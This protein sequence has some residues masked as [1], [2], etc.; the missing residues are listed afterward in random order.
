VAGVEGVQVVAP[1]GFGAV[2]V[3]YTDG[4]QATEFL[5]SIDP[6][7]LN[8][9]LEPEMAQ[10]ALTDLTDGGILVD[11]QRAEDHDLGIGSEVL[12]T[13][14]SGDALVFEV[15][16]ISNE[17]NL[18]GTF[19]VT[20]TEA[21]AIVPE[22]VDAQLYGLVTDGADL[23]TVLAD[24]EKAVADTPGL[25]V[26]DREGFVGSITSQITSF[27]NFVYGMLLLSIIIALIGI[28]NTLSLS[29]NERTRELGLLR[30]VGMDR[31]QLR[32]TIR[33]EA[34]LISV[35]GAAVG[36]GLGLLFSWAVLRT[37]E[38]QGL[39]RFTVP[40]ASL[41]AIMLLAAGL[42]T[43]SSIRPARRAARLEILDAIAEG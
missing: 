37:L 3:T 12:L 18:L 27:V 8:E 38:E 42:G 15:Q 39:S 28:A 35:L 24:I 7:T 9:V 10:G 19:T 29:I 20:R 40:Y 31:S 1:L 23:D 4:A 6:P 13:S 17:P 30:A 33:W 22:I 36:L 11:R 2:Q 21:A 32:S 5:T 43:L 25:Q 41:V 34:A 14:S 16:G 26:L